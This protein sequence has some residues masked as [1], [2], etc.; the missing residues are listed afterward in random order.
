VDLEGSDWFG[1]SELLVVVLITVDNFLWDIDNTFLFKLFG[2]CKDEILVF[3]VSLEGRTA[4]EEIMGMN[5]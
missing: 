1:S 4:H 5:W 2:E 3:D